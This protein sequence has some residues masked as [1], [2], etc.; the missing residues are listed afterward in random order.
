MSR[1]E[2][3]TAIALHFNLTFINS[4]LVGFESVLNFGLKYTFLKMSALF[5]DIGNGFL[6]YDDKRN[7]FVGVM[8]NLKI[9]YVFRF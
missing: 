7:R 6:K 4:D 5:F 3:L 2:P 1:K 9:G 8:G